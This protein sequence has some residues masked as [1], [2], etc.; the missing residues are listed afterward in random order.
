MFVQSAGF[1]KLY[2]NVFVCVTVLLQIHAR[3]ACSSAG[4]SCAFLHANK[5]QRES[6][7]YHCNDDVTDWN[8][9][10][11]SQK[12]MCFSF[13]HCLFPILVLKVSETKNLNCDIVLF[14]LSNRGQK[15]K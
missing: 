5:L 15:A 13:V 3:V 4:R 7:Y 14:F 12:N 1:S 8:S 9:Y 2:T 6:A 10:T 11:L